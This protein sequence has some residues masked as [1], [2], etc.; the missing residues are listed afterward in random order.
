[1]PIWGITGSDCKVA[2]LNTLQSAG[3]FLATYA[4][5]RVVSELG[6]LIARK[7]ITAGN[8]DERFKWAS[9]HG[10]ISCAAGLGVYAQFLHSRVSVVAF[11]PTTAYKLMGGQALLG[12]IAKICRLPTPLSLLFASFSAV[13]YF[14]QKSVVAFAVAGAVAGACRYHPTLR[15]RGNDD[16]LPNLVTI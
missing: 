16:D 11:D 7:Y 1:M 14:G 10:I 13:G 12:V 3:V 4:V 15:P 2:G 9:L 6:N 5:A 8:R